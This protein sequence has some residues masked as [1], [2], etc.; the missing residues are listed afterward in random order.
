MRVRA[1][2]RVRAEGFEGGR[3]GETSR[4]TVSPALSWWLVGFE[5]FTSFL[6]ALYCAFVDVCLGA[7]RGIHTQRYRKVPVKGKGRRWRSG[8]HR[9]V[10]NTSLTCP[11]QSTIS[12]LFGAP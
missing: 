8:A 4:R 5:Y 3:E 7:S 1:Y 2:L 6:A 10:P 11:L 9:H 12:L